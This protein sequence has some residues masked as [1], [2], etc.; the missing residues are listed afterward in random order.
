MCQRHPGG[1]VLVAEMLLLEP[2]WTDQYQSVATNAGSNTGAGDQLLATF[3]MLGA[4]SM[5]QADIPFCCETPEK[6]LQVHATH[7][8]NPRL[9]S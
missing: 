8:S 6:A 4:Y 2:F 9:F 3:N 1:T 7:W 5:R